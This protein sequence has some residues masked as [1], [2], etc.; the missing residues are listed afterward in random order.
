MLTW[1]KSIGP[2]T[3]EVLQRIFSSVK[4][5]ERGYRSCLSILNLTKK[6]SNQALESACQIALTKLYSPRYQQIKAILSHPIP[7][8][9]ASNQPKSSEQLGYIRGAN[10]Y[11]GKEHDKYRD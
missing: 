1:A 5:K 10:Y 2:S 9:E 3:L 11:G 6:Y 7:E 8:P 4:M